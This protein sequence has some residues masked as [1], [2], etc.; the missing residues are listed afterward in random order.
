MW[1]L[2]ISICS[3]GQCGW[4]EVQQPTY[5]DIVSCE[6]SA[7]TIRVELYTQLND[8]RIQIRTECVGPESLE[9]FRQDLLKDDRLTGRM[10]LTI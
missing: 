5:Q 1:T 8:D 6:N 4:L 10:T 7:H 9:Q 2:F 3:L